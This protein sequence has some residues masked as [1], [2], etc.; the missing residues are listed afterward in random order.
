M[1]YW[2]CGSL[3]GADGLDPAG[4]RRHRRKMQQVVRHLP[5][6]DLLALQA[7]RGV[8][9]EAAQ[10]RH[11]LL[12]HSVWVSSY[13]HGRAGGIVFVASPAFVASFDEIAFDVV[14]RGRIGILRCRAS[15]GMS[16]DV[17][18]VHIFHERHSEATMLRMLRES[19]RLAHKS[20]TV[21]IGDFTTKRRRRKGVCFSRVAS[22]AFRLRAQ[23]VRAKF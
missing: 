23:M 12:G 14:L 5:G 9:A 8:A 17:A 18:N 1:R 2:N 3:L 20:L 19:L 6:A 15:D 16:L 22:C 4:L 11:H 21:V 7:V 13:A 10:I